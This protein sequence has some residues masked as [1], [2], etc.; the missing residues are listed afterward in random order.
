MT[1][2]GMILPLVIEANIHYC[3]RKGCGGNNEASIPYWPGSR[4]FFIDSPP[5]YLKAGLTTDG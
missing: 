3:G 2:L 4:V 1:V 5:R